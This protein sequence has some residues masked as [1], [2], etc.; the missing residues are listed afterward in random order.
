MKFIHLLALCAVFLPGCVRSPQTMEQYDR[1]YSR[2]QAKAD[3]A[4]R[5]YERKLEKLQA[6]E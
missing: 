5:K 3:A 1:Q 2:A 4:L 6:T